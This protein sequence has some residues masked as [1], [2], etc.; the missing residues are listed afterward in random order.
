MVQ[1][2]SR[3]GYSRAHINWPKPGTKKIDF[4]ARGLTVCS[5]H[6]QKN[7]RGMEE[8]EKEEELFVI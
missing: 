3:S 8:E 7:T 2:L 4:F 5:T 1:F 6:T